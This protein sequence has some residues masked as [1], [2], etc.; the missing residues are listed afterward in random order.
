MKVSEQMSEELKLTEPLEIL[1]VE[2]L[3]K[4][5]KDDQGQ[6]LPIRTRNWRV[7]V[8]NRFREHMLRPEAYPSGWSSRRYFPARAAR[9]AVAP[10]YPE[11]QQPASKKAN[12]GS[13]PVGFENTDQ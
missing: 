8:P 9:P 2:C 3:T 5:R 12:H 11:Q 4:S 6:I 1:E 13:G 7:K 10:L